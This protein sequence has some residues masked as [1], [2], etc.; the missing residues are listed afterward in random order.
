M[1]DLTVHEKAAYSL[2][3]AMAAL[4]LATAIL[5]GALMGMLGDTEK[6]YSRYRTNSEIELSDLEKKKNELNSKLS[7]IKKQSEKERE[8]Y[9]KQLLAEKLFEQLL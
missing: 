3:A 7:D 8:R 2:T 6:E 4:F 1:K 9:E 5:A